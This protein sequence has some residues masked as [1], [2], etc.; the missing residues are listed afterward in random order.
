LLTLKDKVVFDIKIEYVMVQEDDDFK[1]HSL[2]FQVGGEKYKAP[3][4]VM[5]SE[6][7]EV[8]KEGASE[9]P[10]QIY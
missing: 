5:G 9:L 6:M 7:L 4:R 8:I 10:S 2:M 1:K 3:M